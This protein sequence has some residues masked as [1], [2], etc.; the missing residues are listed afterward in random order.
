MPDHSLRY[1]RTSLLLPTT[2]TTTWVGLN[3]SDTNGTNGRKSLF[4]YVMFSSS[5]VSNCWTSRTLKAPGGRGLHS[6]AGL[7]VRW[8]SMDEGTHAGCV[9]SLPKIR[10][11]KYITPSTQWMEHC[12]MSWIQNQKPTRNHNKNK[13][14]QCFN[15][16]AFRNNVR[17]PNILMPQPCQTNPLTWHA[18]H[19]GWRVVFS[20]KRP[21]TPGKNMQQHEGWITDDQ[22]VP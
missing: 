11:H 12:N 20:G 1:T 14:G 19:P 4:G 21:K 9:L 13:K 3:L 8:I 17:T 2:T 22:W 7:A 16:I 15:P 10:I 5:P 6:L 18:P